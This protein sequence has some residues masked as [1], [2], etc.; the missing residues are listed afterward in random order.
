MDKNFWQLTTEVEQI[1]FLKSSVQG[2][3]NLAFAKSESFK[4]T[5][6]TAMFEFSPIKKKQS[7]L[8][9]SMYFKNRTLYM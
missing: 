6:Y 9:K 7:P 5:Q 8:E 4:N 3:K 1:L 2:V